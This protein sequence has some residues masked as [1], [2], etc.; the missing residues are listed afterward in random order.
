MPSTS[1]ATSR[2]DFLTRLAAAGL[3]VR[4]ATSPSAAAAAEATPATPAT[5]LGYPGPW[6]F[7]LPKGGII[8]VSDEQ[9]TDLTDPDREVDLSL[10]ST[11]HKTTLRRLCQQEQARGTTTLSLAFDEFW[12][13]YRPGQGGKPRRLTPDTDAYLDTLVK[14]GRTL[15]DHGLGFELSLLSPLELG[16]GYLQATGEQGRWVHFREGYRDPATGRYEVGLWEQRHWSN[17]KGTIEL[18]RDGI[19][20][21]AFREQRAGRTSHYVVR[22]Q[23]IVEL[24]ATPELL[25][26]EPQ[27]PRAHQRRLLVRGQ[28]DTQ[29]SN[30]DRVLVVL[31]Y[32][33]PEMDYFSPR[34]WPFLE[35]LLGR[36]HRAGVPLHGLYADETHIQGDWRY[37]NHHDEGQF[38]LRYL[39]PSLARRFAELHGAEF[40]DLERWLV[41]FCAGQ[42]A[43][44]PGL[45]ARLPAQHV[46]GPGLE[47]IQRTWLFRR[48]YYD[49]LER[50]VVDLFV[51]AKRHAESLY[52]HELDAR[53]HATWA[54]SPTIDFWET[55]DAPL[56]P[57][58][59]EYTSDFLW[60]NTVHQAASAC[61]DYFRWNEFLTGGGND[62]AE[63]GWSDRNYYG[64][65][66]ACS[67]GILNTTPNAYAAAWGLPAAAQE[68]R[69]AL[70]N[71][72]GCAPDEPFAA[73]QDHQHRDVPVLML[74]PVSLVA[75][76]ERFGSWMVQYGYANYITPEKLLE[77]AQVTSEGTL[78]LA[79]RTFT[80]LVVLFEPTP[81]PGLL[82]LL[83]TFTRNGGRLLWSGP[84][85][86][87]DL[88]GLPVLV[89]WSEL[90]GI[91][92]R[93][94]SRE[95]WVAA[96][97]RVEFLGSLRPVE[98]QVILTDL[99]VD[100]LYPV[101]ASEGTESVATCAGR[102]VGTRRV[103][104]RGTA[105]YL[106]FR[107]RDDQAASLGYETRTWYA[108]LR[109]A[110]AYPGSGPDPIAS[111]DH[112]CVLSREGPHLV[113]AFPNGT[114]CVASHYHRH[115]ESWPG[116]FHR[117]A[118]RDEEI[119]RSNPLPSEALE[120]EALAIAGHR[121]DRYTGRRLLA[122]R[123]GRTATGAPTL[124]AF[125]GA[126]CRGLS[127]DGVEYWFAEQPLAFLAWAPVVAAR[128]MP[129]GAVLEIWV[130]GTG[131]IRIPV[132]ETVRTPVLALRGARLGTA[133]AEVP[134]T[135]REGFLTFEAAWP[136]GITHLLL[137]DRGA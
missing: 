28:G 54:Q 17:N 76:D 37:N 45:E 26:A 42:H 129:Q 14:I 95:G 23:D 111:R 35:G 34:A 104:G 64:L 132:S 22:P 89:R 126:Q 49:L 114:L 103:V 122:F 61:S 40:A 92:E 77:H 60:S 68:R 46:L 110:G 12:S 59:Y 31:S 86:V 109:E 63:G 18:V 27:D 113:T 83:E 125:A 90:L 124:W 105:W 106:G 91:R 33:T 120:L 98:P 30:G 25:A 100:R 4:F 11:P 72:Y 133:G 67:T 69:R 74:Y 80:T 70:E 2:R 75:A 137:L 20:V 38:A 87:L 84:P 79:G 136:G 81:P 1:A 97:M 3:S 112:P 135:L 101:L 8:L 21:F 78:R 116:G 118:A 56:P 55:G 66:L 15:A 117:D 13:Q 65:A 96:G 85:P 93:A 88:A 52:G 36:Y 94:Y 108:V 43:F 41:Y 82:P 128:R 127:L 57:R 53:A 131:A 39:T 5:V 9:L 51:K 24:K 19:R 71:A 62:H 119:L 7:F 50:T 10:S 58:Q 6:R 123:P 73:I 44:H 99:L 134:A 130:H 102:T 115:V 32:R 16:P 48:R 121:V 29:T 47:E 107:P